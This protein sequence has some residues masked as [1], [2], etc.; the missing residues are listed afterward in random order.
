MQVSY[1]DRTGTFLT[2][3]NKLTSPSDGVMDTVHGQ[4]DALGADTVSLLVYNP[5]NSMC[6]LAWLMD[7]QPDPYFDA[8]A[9]SVVRDDCAVQ[10]LSFPH[11]LGHNFGLEHNRADA[12]NTPSRP[13]AYGYRDS[14]AY[15]RDIMAYDSGGC[16]TQVP[17]F[18]NPDVSYSGRPLG[19]HHLATNAADAARALNDNAQVIGN[20]RQEVLTPVTPITF[21]DDP[22]VAGTT[23]VKAV[24]LTE[25]QNAVNAAR[26]RAGLS[27]HAFSAIVSGGVIRA[28]HV[29]ELRTALAP[30][31]VSTPAYTDPTLTTGN[32]VKAVHVQELRTLT[33]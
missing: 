11:E 6:G 23:K 10:W 14:V 28:A 13:Y 32:V 33:R 20:W 7:G 24:H 25:L 3:L 21:T 9:F 12:T 19:V 5:S 17:Y 26:V 18:S 2:A 29:T 30:A 16:C 27:A 15:F 4:R 31:L 22:I 1:D 8:W